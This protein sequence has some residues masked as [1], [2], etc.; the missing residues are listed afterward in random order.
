MHYINRTGD[1]DMGEKDASEK[2]LED[3]ADVFADIC[4]VLA[5]RGEH[6]L[7]EEDLYP[8][9]TESIYKA[10]SGKLRQQFRDALKYDRRGNALFAVIGLENQSGID[11]DMVFR[12]MKY[13]SASYQYQIDSGNDLRRPVFTLVL[14]FG[15]TPWS[16]P[17]TVLEALK[18]DDLPY[19][20]YVPELIG[21]IKLNIIEVAFLPEEVRAQ[22]Q[23]DFRIIADFFCAMREGRGREFRS[24][25]PFK[26]IKEIIEFF[27]V[28]TRDKRFEECL[29]EM[30]Q[31]AEK[32]ETVS[33]CDLFDYA[34]EQGIAIGHKEGRKEGRIE[35]RKEERE[36]IVANALKAGFPI[37]SIVSLGIPEEEV[38]YYAEKNNLPIN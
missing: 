31:L 29:P 14:Y 33:M 4:N 32:G 5:F 18:I 1:M 19:G 13:D 15:F 6:L 17:R 34:E 9:P 28:F 24:T 23:S 38:R 20:K 10:E 11:Q 3:Y 12:I 36:Q 2:L 37:V 16:G 35:G 21:N 8:G 7:K 25:R 22:F 27:W 26:H 30:L